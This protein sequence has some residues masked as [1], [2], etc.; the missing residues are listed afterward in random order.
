[1]PHRSEDTENVCVHKNNIPNPF[2]KEKEVDGRAWFFFLRR[3]PVIASHK[4]QN[5]NT[6]RAQKLNHFIVKDYFAKL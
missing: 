6:G 4:A 5:L 3:N 1:M 2:V